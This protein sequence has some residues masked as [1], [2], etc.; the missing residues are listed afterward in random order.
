M[1]P[2]VV[3]GVLLAGWLL[4]SSRIRDYGVSQEQR[5]HRIE[6]L[7]QEFPAELGRDGQWLLIGD[8]DIPSNQTEMLGLNAF[9][10]RS[11][12]RLGGSPPICATVFIAHSE[13]ARNMAGHHPPNCYPASGW[14]VSGSG[15]GVV[16]RFVSGG[17]FKL[18]AKMYRYE[19]GFENQVVRWV[20]NGFMM[21]EAGAV[22][23][24]AETTLISGR[25]ATS[26]LGLTQYQI[27]IDGDLEMAEVERYAAEIIGSIPR[28][29]LVAVTSSVESAEQ[30]LPGGES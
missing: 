1:P 17:G 4:G 25:A 6:E 8:V 14:V 29:L 16:R 13:D 10:S 3:T 9:V 21:P 23:T 7:F 27:V 30:A 26:R 11:F 2:L 19:R 18:P 20:I 22:A 12:R 5:H 15:D 24:L 28:E